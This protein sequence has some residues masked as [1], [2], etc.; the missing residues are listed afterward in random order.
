MFLSSSTRNLIRRIKNDGLNVNPNMSHDFG[1]TQGHGAADCPTLKREHGRGGACLP[2]LPPASAPFFFPYFMYLSRGRTIKQWR[3][4]D[5]Q[6]F[7]RLHHVY[8]YN[9]LVWHVV[10]NF[11][12]HVVVNFLTILLVKFAISLCCELVFSLP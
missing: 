7:G 9:T 3:R 1:L 12:N 5:M 10:V 11:S 6:F 4:F 8:I 2:H